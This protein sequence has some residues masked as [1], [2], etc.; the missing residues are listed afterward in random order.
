V[1]FSYLGRKGTAKHKARGIGRTLY[2]NLS[3]YPDITEKCK[4]SHPSPNAVL[5]LAVKNHYAYGGGGLS[6]AEKLK[7]TWINLE[8][9]PSAYAEAGNIS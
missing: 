8:V 6:E 1:K 3:L 4:Y 5:K 9:T 2:N 7:Y